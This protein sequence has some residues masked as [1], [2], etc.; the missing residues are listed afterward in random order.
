MQKQQFKTCIINTSTK[1][2][3]PPRKVLFRDVSS[4]DEPSMM[5]SIPHSSDLDS[6]I[7]TAIDG[8]DIISLSALMY[9]VSNQKKKQPTNKRFKPITFIEPEKSVAIQFDDTQVDLHDI[10]SL[11][12]NIKSAPAQH[13]QESL[14]PINEDYIPE[15]SSES[16]NEPTSVVFSVSTVSGD[17]DENNCQ[18]DIIPHRSGTF[19]QD[20]YRIVSDTQSF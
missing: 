1:D 16:T 8:S 2:S 4:M 5:L 14:K 6:T 20:I 10:C 3:N 12:Y 17:N 9:G 11:E 19:I 18:S 13:T 7:L 15:Y